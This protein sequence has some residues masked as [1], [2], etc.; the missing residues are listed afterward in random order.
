MNVV[1][2]ALMTRKV[3]WYTEVDVPIGASMIT[4]LSCEGGKC[5]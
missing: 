2:P 4:S 3:V 1:V 5:A